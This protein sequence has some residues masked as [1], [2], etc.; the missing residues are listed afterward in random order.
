[1]INNFLKILFIVAVLTLKCS[2]CNFAQEIDH[3]ETL[4]MSNDIWKYFIGNV[5]PPSNWAATEFDDSSW[6]NGK[7]GIGY[8][9]GDDSTVISPAGSVYMRIKFNVYDADAVGAAILFVDFDDG[10]VAYLND[11]EIARENIGTPGVRPSHDEYAILTSYEAQMLSGGLPA[12]FVINYDTLL[13]YLRTGENVLALQVHNCNSTSSDLSSTTFLIFGIKS[14]ERLYRPA[15][16]W[17]IEPKND[18]THLPIIVIDTKNQEIPDEPKI[19]VNLKVINNGPGTMNSWLQP[20]TDF[21]GQAS[22]EI[23]GQSTQM[24]PKKSYSIELKD[25]QGNDISVPLLGMPAE[26]DWILHAHYTDKTMIR[27]ALTLHLGSKMGSWQPRFRYCVVYLNGEYNGVYLLIEKIKRDKERL[28]ISRLRREDVAGD[29]VTGGYILK[30]DKIGGLTSNDY[31]VSYPYIIYP[32]SRNYK[33]TYVY[34]KS[35]SIVYEQREYIKKYITDFQNVLNDKDFKDPFTGYKKYIDPSSFIDFQ[36][37]QELTN[38]VDGYRFSTFFYKKKDT[39][40]GKLY[41]GPLWDFDLCYGNVNYSDYNLSTSG[42]LYPHCGPTD[43][44]TMHWWKRLMEDPD[45]VRNFIMRW[46]EL[47]KTYFSTENIMQFIDSIVLYLGPEIDRNYQKWPILGKYVWPNYFIGK[48]YEEEINYLKQWINDRLT[49]MDAQTGLNSSLYNDAFD[50]EFIAYPNPFDEKIKLI[51]S[52]RS[53]LPVSM[54]IY[55]FMGRMCLNDKIIP[56]YSGIQQIEKDFS[57]LNNGV[58]IIILKQSNRIIGKR[59][60]IKRL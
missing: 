44:Y 41:A 45:Y 22:I 17:F 53:T 58:Y 37:I 15:P 5:E 9:D 24:F 29:E 32:N 48:T 35:D 16:S 55:D 12:R 39:Q 50:S 21:D 1:M 43:A 11:H 30:V 54:E 47:R 38:N 33:F 34:P 40:G 52:T 49:W 4:V 14:E 3:W 25:Y 56:E 18:L 7:G 28:D 6:L 26:E 31:F 51:F 13:K 19:I 8:G 27:Y 23:H 42:W 36:I 57:E 59:I 20:G 10:F 2:V 46:N 60:V